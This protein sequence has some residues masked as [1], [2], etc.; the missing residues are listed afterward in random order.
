MIAE[1][2]R[3]KEIADT[4]H[5]S[6]KTVKTHRANLMK[7]LDIHSAAS[8]GAYAAKTGLM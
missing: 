6:E 4:L 5:I 3:N 2:K 8:L 7:K 1:G